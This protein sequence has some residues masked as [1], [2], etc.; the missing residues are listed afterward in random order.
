MGS[1][2]A[3]QFAADGLWYRVKLTRAEEPCYRVFYVDYGNEEVVERSNLR[4][5][6]TDFSKLPPLA[7]KLSISE[8]Q[9]GCE[10]ETWSKTAIQY[11]TD[12]VFDHE[13][14]VVFSG[15]KGN[16]SAAYCNLEL[17]NQLFL[18]HPSE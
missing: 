12:K 9:M 18:C 15:E 13:V 14:K 2:Y 17:T 8:T 3:C 6:K 7:I 11:F 16:V 10:G 4:P 1:I 5:L